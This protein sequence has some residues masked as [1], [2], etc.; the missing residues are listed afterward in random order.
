MPKV[1]I[2]IPCFNHGAFLP[3]TLASLEAQSFRC[4]EIII[5]DDGSTDQETINLYDQLDTRGLRVIRT[6]NNGVSAA[7]NRGITEATGKFILTLDADDC[8]GTEYLTKALSV[9]E[10]HSNAGIVFCERQMFG[11][12]SGNDPLPQYDARRL[13]IE[14]LIYPAALFRKEDWAMVGGYN[15]SMTYGWEDWDFWIAL[16]RL[17]KVVIK[18]PEA[19]FFYRVRS[20]SRDHSLRFSRKLQMFWLMVLRHRGHYLHHMPYVCLQLCRIHLFERLGSLEKN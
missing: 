17:D 18:L 4:F 1:S 20:A 12:R 7:R 11:E 10:K 8:I 15:E 5:V 9:F 19:M 14:N 16:S 13:L 6:A 3:E 2:V